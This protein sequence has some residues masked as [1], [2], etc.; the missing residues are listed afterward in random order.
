VTRQ[1]CRAQLS[2]GQVLSISDSTAQICFPLITPPNA[3][4]SAT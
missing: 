2:G 1:A 3:G 4:M